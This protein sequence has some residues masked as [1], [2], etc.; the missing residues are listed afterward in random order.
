MM[1]TED[2]WPAVQALAA[3]WSSSPLVQT[4]LTRHPAHNDSDDVVTEALRNLQGGVT[5]LTRDTTVDEY[6]GTGCPTGAVDPAHRRSARLP[7]DDRAARA[8][9]GVDGGMGT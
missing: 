5:V 4:F 6:M 7:A 3:T 8:C 9:G 2:V 1:S